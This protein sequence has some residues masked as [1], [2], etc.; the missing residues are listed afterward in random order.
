MG[1]RPGNRGQR[2][3]GLGRR[4]NLCDGGKREFISAKV[5]ELDL[6]I[7]MTNLDASGSISLILSSLSGEDEQIAEVQ[8]EVLSI[9]ASVKPFV[10]LVWMGVILMVVGFTISVVRRTKET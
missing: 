9:E 3:A 2:V 8:P 7:E 10:N 5:E 1:L 6:M 4:E